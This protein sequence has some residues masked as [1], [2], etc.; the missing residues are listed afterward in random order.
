MASVADIVGLMRSNPKGIRFADACRVCDHYSG[1]PRQEGSS[2]RVYKTPWQ[3]DPRVN[4]QSARGKAK[5]YQVKQVLKA[6]E[7]LEYEA[8]SK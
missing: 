5:A 6:M 7:R 2:H 8:R 1:K 4:L 3:G